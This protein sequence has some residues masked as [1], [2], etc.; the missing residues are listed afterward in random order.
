MDARVEPG[1]DEGKSARSAKTPRRDWQDVRHHAA[2][3]AGAVLTVAGA[4]L[5]LIG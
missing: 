2:I 5:V 4:A 3:V 1:H